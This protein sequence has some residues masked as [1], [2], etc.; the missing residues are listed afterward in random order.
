LECNPGLKK[1]SALGYTGTTQLRGD[2][3][4]GEKNIKK[5]TKKAPKKSIKE[6][7]KEKQEKKKNK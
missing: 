3:P 6:K 2:E 7:R 4:M 1:R 5:E